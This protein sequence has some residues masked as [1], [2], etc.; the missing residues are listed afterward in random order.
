MKFSA[1]FLALFILVPGAQNA[2]SGPV[3]VVASIFPLAD[4][5]RNIGGE[6]VETDILLTPGRGPHSYEPTPGDMRKIAKAHIVLMAGFGLDDWAVKLVKSAGKEG[7]TLIDLSKEVNNPIRSRGRK[8][9]G[10]VNPHYWLDPSI[11]VAVA[12]S[13]GSALIH[14]RPEKRDEI[15]G[16]MEEYI[17]ALKTLDREIEEILGADGSG[18]NY[19]SFH[20]AW[21]Y[22]ARRYNLNQIGVIKNSHGKEPS[23]KHIVRLIEKIKNHKVYAILIEYQSSP[24]VSQTVADEADVKLVQVD[25][26]GGAPGRESYIKLM[27]WNAKRFK[28]AL[29]R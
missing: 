14:A 29:N 28:E 1:L 25:P 10:S 19:V 21:A 27:L 4:V 11:M 2:F 7:Q 20:N 5:A 9:D 15:T 13:I 16:R 12:R 17:K 22:F 8:G 18:K 26:I 24:G 23:A 3:G 6:L